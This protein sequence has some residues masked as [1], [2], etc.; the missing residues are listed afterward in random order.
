MSP[1]ASNLNRF[2]K[3]VLAISFAL[4]AVGTVP[5]LWHALVLR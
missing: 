2:E 5:V 1:I 4:I 3:V